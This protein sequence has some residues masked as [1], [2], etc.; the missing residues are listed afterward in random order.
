[1]R[2]SK[3]AAHS[4][5]ERWL[6]SY[7]DFITLLFAFFVVLYSSAQIDK[8]KVGKLAAAIEDGFQEMGTFTATK[9]PSNQTAAQV[10]N[11]T[12]AKAVSIT[13]DQQEIERLRGELEH[14]LASEIE[15]QEVSVHIGPDGLVLSL[16]EGGFFSSGSAQMRPEAQEAFA[17]IVRVISEQPYKLRVEGH[18]DNVP[19][20]NER[21]NSNW[22]LSASR[23]T[24]VVRLLLVQGGFHPENLAAAGYAEFHPAGDN[25][26]EDGRRMNRRVDVVVLTTAPRQEKSR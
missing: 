1:M 6:V 12:P 16:R 5:H 20:H 13:P 14:S 8:R 26:T 11:P 7:A 25:S 21:F 17:R 22:E 19:I 2:R 23:A 18:T 10:A 15:R 9:R 3:G 24:E 4:S